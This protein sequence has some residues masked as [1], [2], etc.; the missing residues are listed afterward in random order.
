MKGRILQ[1]NILEESVSPRITIALILLSFAGVADAAEPA[2]ID[3]EAR[4]KDTVRPF[5]ASYCVSCHSGEKAP[6]L[7]DLSRY[8]TPASV[9]E[10]HLKWALLLEK[11]NAKEMPPATSPKQP[12][13]E[14]RQRVVDWV[15]ALLKNE[16][17]K[18]AGDPGVVLARRL[19]NSEYNYTIRDLTGV[20]IRPTR[21]FPVDPSNMAGF[22]NSGESLSMSPT[23]VNKYLQAAREVADHLILKP[24]GIAFAPHLALVETDRDR[25]C[26]NQIIDFY[27]RQITDYSDYFLTAWRYKHRVQLGK[28]KASLGDFAAEYNLSPKYLATVWSALETKEDIGPLATLQ[29]MWKTLAVP[30]GNQP[31]FAKPGTDVMRDWV[32]ELRH[33]IATRVRMIE[34]AI[35]D[36]VA[37]QQPFLMWRNWQYARNRRN[38]DRRALQVEGEEPVDI[39]QQIMRPV[40]G[41]DTA[42]MIPL[43]EIPDPDLHVPAG[44][45]QRYEAAFAKF[46][47]V[48]PDTFYVSER[49]RYF[50]YA[51]RATDVGRHLSAGFH[52]NMGYF[53]DDQPLYELILDER[54]KKELDGHWRDLDFVAG[55]LD[56][57]YT[58]FYLAGESGAARADALEGGLTSI[59]V[60]GIFSEEKISKTKEFYLGR[61]R[62]NNPLAVEAVEQHFAWVNENFRWLEKARVESEPIHLAEMSKFAAR[63]YRRPLSQA[64]RDGLLSFYTSSREENG[65]THEEAMRDMVVRVLM[66]PHFLYRLD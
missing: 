12:A 10:D 35:T 56:R 43:P 65:L 59:D 16:A 54:Q 27:N 29:A 62:P 7:F 66:S 20:D 50:P 13:D 17:R 5:L 9:A 41:R 63:A 8:T 3:L 58:Q 28:P 30:K 46:A 23:L 26:I 22:D 36:G 11:L 21:E 45:R 51:E 38:F 2:K 40:A 44:Q 31:Y 19:S 24:T 42:T 57:T 37:I 39:G 47:S 14:A 18:N 6:A 60:Q 4:F 53:R 55:G 48:F 34:N 49:G 25:Y 61:L 64:E 52:N 33:K 15:D 1:V 32:V